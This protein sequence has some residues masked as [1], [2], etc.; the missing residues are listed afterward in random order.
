[1]STTINEHVRLLSTAVNNLWTGCI[2]KK[3]L[4]YLLR[5]VLRLRLAP[6]REKE[7]WNRTH[8]DKEDNA[9]KV[10]APENPDKSDKAEP[11]QKQE[12]AE[13]PKM[14]RRKW[15]SWVRKTVDRLANKISQRNEGQISHILGILD[16]MASSKPVSVQT[17]IPNIHCR[18]LE[19][20]KVSDS[21]TKRYPS[22]TVEDCEE[23]EDEDEDEE[24]DEVDGNSMLIG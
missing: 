20:P 15:K 13:H 19:A 7:Y 11:P 8:K 22:P 24:E 1:M 14:N 21:N 4:D 3:S 18:L 12:K 2:Y 9:E 5:I 17:S 23:E 10:P 16:K 6:E